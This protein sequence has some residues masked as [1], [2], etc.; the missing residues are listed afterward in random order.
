MLGLTPTAPHS[1]STGTGRPQCAISGRSPTASRTG[2]IDR[3]LAA[4]TDLKLS[5]R[6]LAELPPMSTL[7]PPSATARDPSPTVAQPLAIRRTGPPVYLI[8]N[9]VTRTATRTAAC[10][11]REMAQRRHRDTG[12]HEKWTSH[13]SM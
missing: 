2:H 9:V 10:P 1:Y 5:K 13:I 4:S 7:A 6:H 3:S 12:R 8:F 11:R